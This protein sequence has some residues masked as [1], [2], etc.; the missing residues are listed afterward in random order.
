MKHSSTLKKIES[1]Y[2]NRNNSMSY[3]H[4]QNELNHHPPSRKKRKLEAKA[5]QHQANLGLNAQESNKYS[6]ETVNRKSILSKSNSLHLEIKDIGDS[7]FLQK[8]QNEI[9]FVVKSNALSDSQRIARQKTIEKLK[10]VLSEIS[11]R[12][13]TYGSFTTGLSLPSSDIDVTV[14]TNQSSHTCISKSNEETQKAITNVV[15]KLHR[16]SLIKN[17]TLQIIRSSKV[18]L[19]KFTYKDTNIPIDITINQESGLETILLVKPILQTNSLV[20]NLIIFIKC[21]LRQ[22]SLNDASMGGLSSFVIF[23]MVYTYAQIFEH[24]FKLQTSR[25]LSFFF[26]GFLKFFSCEFDYNNFALITHQTESLPILKD[27]EKLTE[28][29]LL[30]SNRSL[31]SIMLVKGNFIQHKRLMFPQAHDE[32]L[33]IQS[34]LDSSIDIGIAAREYPQVRRLFAACFH[35]LKINCKQTEDCKSQLQMLRKIIKLDSTMNHH[36]SCM[37]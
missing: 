27:S 21:L 15:N 19:I 13:E 6:D 17:G 22:Y 32:S 16:Y 2:N 14:F 23:H 34:I 24:S 30:S 25:L 29:D 36:H 9:E 37:N 4:K 12:V 33:S 18:P 10:V 3:D 28:S 7:Q 20:R 35:Q 5:K 11:L 1:T 26:I 31:D 8:L